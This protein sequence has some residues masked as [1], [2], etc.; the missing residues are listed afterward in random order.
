MPL[1]IYNRTSFVCSSKIFEALFSRARKIV[2]LQEE[3]ISLAILSRGDMRRINRVY[4]ACD[5][6]TDV[7]SFDY[8]E[9]LLCPAYIK[10]KYRLSSS[11]EIA[12]KMRELFI[13]G[14]VHIAGFRHGT[15]KQ[16]RAMQ[17]V[18]EKIFNPNFND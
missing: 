18:E 5:E 3:E 13:H 12:E 16:E 6:P 4:R 7:L 9:I 2:K 14:L 1:L 11:R 17:K 8:G 15:K 10:E